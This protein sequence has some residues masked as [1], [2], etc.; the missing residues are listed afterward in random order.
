MPKFM[1]IFIGREMFNC[2]FKVDEY[3]RI[4]NTQL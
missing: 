2:G 3:R 1:L 4:G